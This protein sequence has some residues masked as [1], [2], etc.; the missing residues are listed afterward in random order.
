MVP[1]VNSF[2]ATE[3]GFDGPA[4]GGLTEIEEGRNE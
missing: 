1:N 2:R 4:E 3:I